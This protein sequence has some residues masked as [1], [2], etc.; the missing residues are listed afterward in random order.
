M[1]CAQQAISVFFLFFF[2]KHI[3]S[4]VTHRWKIC[5]VIFEH[6]SEKQFKMKI[7]PTRLF[8]LHSILGLC[9]IFMKNK[10]RKTMKIDT[11]H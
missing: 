10:Q 11:Q 6:L 9:V 3:L 5:L 4:I 2:E 8:H 1:I 7:S